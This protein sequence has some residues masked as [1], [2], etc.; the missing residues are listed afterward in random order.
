MRRIGERQRQH[1]LGVRCKLDVARLATRI[2]NGDAPNLGLG[3]R[4]HDD[5]ESRGKRAVMPHELGAIFGEHDVV[6][7]RPRAAWLVG[8]R[9]N[10][11]ACDVAQQDITAPIVTR[12]ILAPA[13]DGMLGPSAV[14]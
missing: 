7:V 1:D 6:A 8:R 5:V 11:A 9:P 14:A 3:L 13:R 2:E 10:L 12:R 4:R